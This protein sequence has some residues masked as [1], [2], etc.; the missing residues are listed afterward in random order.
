VV[1]VVR[2]LDPGVVADGEV[3]VVVGAVVVVPGA[4]VPGAVVVP[5][6]VEAPDEEPEDE[7]PVW[8]GPPALELGSLPTQLVSA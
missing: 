2:V 4:V 6:G 8:E 1:P 5:A 3:G 7:G